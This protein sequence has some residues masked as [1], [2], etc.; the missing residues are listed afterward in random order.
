[1]ENIVGLKQLR[2]NV[3]MYAK[4]V[5]NGD[6]FLVMKKSTPLFRIVPADESE[7]MWEEVID[8]TKI[9]KGGVAINDILARL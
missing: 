6:S 4:K 1:M 7:E 9:K 8:F 3:T 2:E 5:K